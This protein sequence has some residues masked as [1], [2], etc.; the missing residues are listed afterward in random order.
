MMNNTSNRKNDD[1]LH[2]DNLVNDI[3]TGVQI[4]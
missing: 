4:I 3:P 1:G 2:W